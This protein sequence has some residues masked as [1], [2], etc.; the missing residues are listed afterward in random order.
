MRH[1]KV[2][3]LF[4]LE[5]IVYRGDEQNNSAFREIFQEDGMYVLEG[6]ANWNAFKKNK[7]QKM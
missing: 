4:T 2:W 5:N 7:C 6:I 3:T 1:Q